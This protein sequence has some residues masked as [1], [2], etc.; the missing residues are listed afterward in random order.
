MDIFQRKNRRFAKWTRFGED[1]VFSYGFHQ[2]KVMFGCM[3]SISMRDRHESP[4]ERKDC[5]P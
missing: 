2:F 5:R 4:H 3:V 1:R